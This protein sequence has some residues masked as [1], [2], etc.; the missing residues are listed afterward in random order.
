MKLHAEASSCCYMV[1]ERV[2]RR[3]HVRMILKK[4]FEQ[5]ESTS[6]NTY[7][8]VL[9]EGIQVP[10]ALGTGFVQGHAHSNNCVLGT[11][12]WVFGIFSVV[13]ISL[14]IVVIAIILLIEREIAESEQ[15]IL[16]VD[17]RKQKQHSL[18]YIYLQRRCN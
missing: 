5:I 16:L 9:V 2:R 8:L 10:V 1:R 3:T 6:N 13:S 18:A 11:V 4:L 17:N 7:A 15:N 12:R 14:V